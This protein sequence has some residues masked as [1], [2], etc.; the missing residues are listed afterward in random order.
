MKTYILGKE[1]K[2][3]KLILVI[4]VEIDLIQ[5]TKQELNN[6]EKEILS[7]IVTKGEVTQK[8]L[9]EIFGR[10]KACRT[11]RELEQKGFIIRERYG[12]TFKIRVI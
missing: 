4:K 9:G 1:Y 8:Q 6:N 10:A 3:K 11:V 2:D 12:R 5:D 7:L